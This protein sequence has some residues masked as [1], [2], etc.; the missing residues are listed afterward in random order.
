MDLH[1]ALVDVLSDPRDADAFDIVKIECSDALGRYAFAVT[2][3]EHNPEDGSPKGPLRKFL[4]TVSE[5][6]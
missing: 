5:V 4:V 6:K 3:R 1:A 2:A